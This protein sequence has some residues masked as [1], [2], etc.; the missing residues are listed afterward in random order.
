MYV[1]VQDIAD[2]VNKMVEEWQKIKTDI[3]IQ[4]VYD[5]MNKNRWEKPIEIKRKE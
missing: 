4:I 2:K 5:L 3:E 1:I